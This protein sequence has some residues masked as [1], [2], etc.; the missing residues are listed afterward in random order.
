MYELDDKLFE[1]TDD[2]LRIAISK[3]EKEIKLLGLENEVAAEFRNMFII[4]W[5]TTYRTFIMNKKY[6]YPPTS[7][8]KKSE[9]SPAVVDFT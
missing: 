4:Q 7:I 6:S 1:Y 3:A 8:K 2:V 5:M 9:N